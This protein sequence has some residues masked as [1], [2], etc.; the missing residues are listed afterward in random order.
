MYV[1]EQG[2]IYTYIRAKDNMSQ[3]HHIKDIN[4][5]TFIITLLEAAERCDLQSADGSINV[6]GIVL[7]DNVS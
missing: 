2:D 1:T 5:S 6:R 7:C 3:D 4:L